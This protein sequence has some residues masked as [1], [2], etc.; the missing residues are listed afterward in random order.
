MEGRL[1]A[2]NLEQHLAYMYKKNGSVLAE[3]TSMSVV[4]W[5]FE[6]ASRSSSTC[7]SVRGQGSII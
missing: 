1:S 5:V 2:E 6:K 7:D 4:I 3:T